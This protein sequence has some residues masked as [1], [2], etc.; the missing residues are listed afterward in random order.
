MDD[1]EP[2]VLPPVPT[3]APPQFEVRL[4]KTTNQKL[5][6]LSDEATRYLNRGHS[7]IDSDSA[8][9]EAKRDCA[10]YDAGLSDPIVRVAARNRLQRGKRHAVNPARLKFSERD[11]THAMTKLRDAAASYDSTKDRAL[12]GYDGKAM[13]HDVLASVLFKARG[14]PPPP[15]KEE[16]GEKGSVAPE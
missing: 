13:D 10:L 16:T 1:D 4:R 14:T 2:L 7:L 8:L 15:P 9:L 12:K 11:R 5:I 3:I 6:E